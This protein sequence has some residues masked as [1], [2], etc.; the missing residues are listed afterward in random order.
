MN[1][2]RWLVVGTGDIATKRVIPA[3]ESERRSTLVAVC[4][5]VEERAKAAATP[6]NA[7]VHT[8][9]SE[10]LSCAD[11]DA[12]YLC[13]P[14]F[15]HVPQALQSLAA[16]KHVL[17]EKPVALN[18]PEAQRLVNATRTSDRACGVAYFRRFAPKYVLTQEMLRKGEFGKVV[19]VRMTYFSWFNPAQNDPKYWRVIPERSGGGPISDMGTHMFDVLIGLLGMPETVF[20]KAETLVQPYAVEDSSVAILKMPGGAQVLASFHWS[21]KTWSHEFEIIGA[22]A[23]VKW[24]PYDSDSVVKTV[25]RDTVEVPTPN[26]KN[27]HAPLVEDFV[28]AVTENRAPAV[29]AAEA[30]KTN[31]VVDALY[32]SARERREVALSEI[33]G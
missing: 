18:Y 2:V 15:L 30:A 32:R 22:E 14:V 33:G 26:A 24:H 29:T 17:V 7:R 13:T 6:R 25:G 27:V 10:A 16:G 20:A 3:I 19:L 28:T 4:D 9:L 8:D 12:V 23:K 31:A 21:S 1:R 11:I 5:K